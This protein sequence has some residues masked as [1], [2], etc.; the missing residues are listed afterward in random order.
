MCTCVHS[1]VGDFNVNIHQARSIAVSLANFGR[2]PLEQIV[3]AG[4]WKLSNV[5][6]ENYLRSLAFFADSLYG[7]RPL[8]A[9]NTNV[10]LPDEI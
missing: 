8:V 10:C 3:L 2:V 4:S 1:Y 5:F 6:T 7:L 9:F